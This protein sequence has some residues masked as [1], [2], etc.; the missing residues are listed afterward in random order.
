MI[1][2]LVDF[3]VTLACLTASS[4]K[5]RTMFRPFSKEL[6]IWGAQI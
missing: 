6:Y 4:R 2:N 5:Y 1:K 3:Y